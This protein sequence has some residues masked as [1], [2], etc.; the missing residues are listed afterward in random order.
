MHC[1]GVDGWLGI[2]FAFVAC[3]ALAMDGVH[4]LGTR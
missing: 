2:G 3:G 1:D 4:G